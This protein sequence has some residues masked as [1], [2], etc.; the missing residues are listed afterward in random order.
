MYH[1]A[2]QNE[3]VC[4]TSLATRVFII[5][6]RRYKH[7]TAEGK[8]EACGG[9]LQLEESVWIQEEISLIKRTRASWRDG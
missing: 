9:V 6:G 5:G 1:R 3:Y 4:L 8:E 7:G 2:E